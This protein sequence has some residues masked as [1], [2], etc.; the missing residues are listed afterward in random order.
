MAASRRGGNGSTQHS[1]LRSGAA[2]EGPVAVL[3]PLRLSQGDL[4][5]LVGLTRETVNSILH[6]WRD[7]GVVEMDRRSI[8]VRDPERLR[9]VR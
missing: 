2:A 6:A 1:C 7:Q 3:I 5:K 8:R 9:R 4:G